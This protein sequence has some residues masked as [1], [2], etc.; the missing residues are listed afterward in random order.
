MAVFCRLELAIGD[1]QKRIWFPVAVE[2]MRLQNSKNKVPS[3]NSQMQEGLNSDVQQCYKATRED[4]WRCLTRH[5]LP[6]GK[7]DG[8]PTKV[9]CNIYLKNHKIDNKGD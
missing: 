9:L 3:P 1:T 6:Q 5:G 7:P 2:I 8:K 4:L